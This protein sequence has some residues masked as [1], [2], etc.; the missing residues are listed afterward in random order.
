MNTTSAKRIVL[1][2]ND[3]K[4]NGAERV[5]V[6]LAHAFGR[7]GHEVRIIC[8]NNTIE[9]DTTG[10]KISHFPMRRW[11]WIPRNIRG[12]VVGR[13]LDSF[14][15][16]EVSCVPDLILSNLLPCD[17]L[18]SA[19]QLPNVYLVLHN[20][21]SKERGGWESFPEMGIYKRKPVVCVSEGVRQDYVSLF[22]DHAS[23][24]VT[25]KNPVDVEWV[26]KE[27]EITS[28]HFP[29]PY[30]VH[31][32][33]FKA[34][35]RHDVLLKAF[36]KSSFQGHLVLVGQGALQK[37]AE[38]LATELGIREKVIFAGQMTNP[39]PT[40]KNAAL[41]VLSSDFEGLGMVL[42]E[43]VALGTPVL[44]TD[45]PCGPNEIVGSQQLVPPGDVEALA[46]KLSAETYSQYNV[47]WNR[48][49]DL[50]YA[51]DRYLLLC[52]HQRSLKD[53]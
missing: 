37:N 41:L 28:R 15:K 22:P 20:V 27:A 13:L 14:I 35:K 21:L 51:R 30:I 7:A 47:S 42:L 12:L 4:G 33:K 31:V 6:T 43:A 24:A 48:E 8:F 38:V 3:L 17:R 44:S 45:C 52:L 46:A 36:A 29:E 49:F 50:T 34:E 18:L 9:Y 32:G 39:F 1:V 25:I 40:I 26:R 23:D 53:K 11:R 5:V 19:S 10:L 2:I 16:R